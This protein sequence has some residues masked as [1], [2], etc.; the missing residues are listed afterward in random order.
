MQVFET[1]ASCIEKLK[2]GFL[3]KE[4]LLLEIDDI[5][6]SHGFQIS[7]SNGNNEY[8]YLVCHR[9]GKSKEINVEKKLIKIQKRKGGTQNKLFSYIFRLSISNFLYYAAGK[10]LTPL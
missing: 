5:V 2:K 6:V 9:A 3:S 7:K 4:E 1:P 8:I 10:V